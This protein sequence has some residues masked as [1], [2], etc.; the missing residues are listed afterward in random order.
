[1]KLRILSDLHLEFYRRPEKSRIRDDVDCDVVIMAG[2]I[3]TSTTG[4][5]WAAREFTKPV[6]YVLGNHEF[7]GQHVPAFIDN[8]RQFA[9]E[10]GVHLLENDEVQIGGQRFIGSTL[11][12]DFGSGPLNWIDAARAAHPVVSDFSEI[13]HY[14]GQLISPSLMAEWHANS[15]KWLEQRLCVDDPAVVVTHFAPTWAVVDP[16][17][18]SGDALTPYFHSNLEHLMGEA[19]PL[20]IYGHNHYSADV[21]VDTDRGNTRVISNQRGYRDEN[22]GFDASLVIDL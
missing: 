1:M 9:N 22:A 16:R 2:D 13:R 18:G 5:A 10:R 12:T 8:A 15:V 20:W 3:H 7:Y 4:I 11:W 14:Y 19:A 17:F 21:T 6:V